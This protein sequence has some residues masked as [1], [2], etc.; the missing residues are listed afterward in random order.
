LRYLKRL[1]HET[2]GALAGE[3]GRQNFPP[4][5]FVDAS[6]LHVTIVRRVE[7]QQGPKVTNGRSTY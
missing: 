2:T 7:D 6:A 1:S 5:G 4:R 3:C